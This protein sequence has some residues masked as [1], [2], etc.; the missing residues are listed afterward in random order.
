MPWFDISMNISLW[1]DIFHS[2][3]IWYSIYDSVLIENLLFASENILSKLIETD[4]DIRKNFTFVKEI[5]ANK[6]TYNKYWQIF[7]ETKNSIVEETFLRQLRCFEHCGKK[8]VEILNNL[9]Q[10]KLNFN[11]IIQG[12]KK[13]KSM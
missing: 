8:C 13:K 9:F 1:V 5:N 3:S 11:K 6:I 12:L 10:T 4:S 7:A 2:M